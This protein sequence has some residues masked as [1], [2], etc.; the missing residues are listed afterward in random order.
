MTRNA[1]RIAWTITGIAALVLL[2]LTVTLAI[3]ARSL[4]QPIVA[5]PASPAPAGDSDATASP[6]RIAAT[7]PADNGLI[8]FSS[9]RDGNVEIYVMQPDGSDIR[10]ITD[11]PAEDHSPSWTLDGSRLVWLRSQQ[12]VDAAPAWS[13]MTAAPDGSDQ[14]TVITGNGWLMAAAEN[15]AAAQAALYVVEDGNENGEPDL[16]DPHRLLLIDLANLD[17]QP[18]DLLAVSEGIAPSPRFAN[19]VLQWSVDGTTLYLLLTVN[20]EDGLYALPVAGGP[21]ELISA[22]QVELAALSPDGTQMAIWR[23]FEDTGR[24]QR[25]L[26]LHNLDTGLETPFLM[27]GLAFQAINGLQWSR[28]GSQ[29]VFGGFTGASTPDIY[30]LDAQLDELDAVSQQVADPAFEPALSPDG[31]QIVFQAQPFRASG[32]GF[33]P[34]GDAN[35]YLV[36]H[37]GDDAVQLTDQQGNNYDAAWQPVFR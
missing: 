22:G 5:A 18:L 14:R 11:D 13:A 15:P 4:P 2:T 25:R 34:A 10:R 36:D 16:D 7:G 17:A 19:G 9:D 23:A 21:P 1:L 37:L 20:D 30:V 3:R 32:Q 28:D 8:A 26:F 24:R 33:E 29:L 31:A 27:G 6:T 12:A 35:L